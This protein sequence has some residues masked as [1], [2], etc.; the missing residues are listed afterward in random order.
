MEWNICGE[1]AFKQKENI[2]EILRLIYRDL[3]ILLRNNP[4]G[5]VRIIQEQLLLLLL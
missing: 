1:Y 4:R 2:N 5:H 3:K